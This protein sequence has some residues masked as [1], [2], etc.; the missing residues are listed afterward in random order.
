MSDLKIN[1]NY[2]NFYYYYYQLPI[3]CYK[4]LWH[5]KKAK[6]FLSEQDKAYTPIFPNT[7]KS[8]E[9]QRVISPGT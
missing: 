9:K 5:S 7:N 1:V 3:A 2:Y 8:H 4:T 6:Y